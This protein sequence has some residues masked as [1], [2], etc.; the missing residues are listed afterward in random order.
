MFVFS[1]FPT[2]LSVSY[3]GMREASSLFVC[4]CMRLCVGPVGI[5]HQF[6]LDLMSRHVEISVRVHRSIMMSV[7]MYLYANFFQLNDLQHLEQLIFLSQVYDLPD[8]CH[9]CE[10]IF[11]LAP[12]SIQRIVEFARMHGLQ[13]LMTRCEMM[14][15]MSSMPSSTSSHS[16]Q[17]QEVY[18]RFVSRRRGFH[19]FFDKKKSIFFCLF[20]LMVCQSLKW[21]KKSKFPGSAMLVVVVL[22]RK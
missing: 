2:L 15:Q 17:M 5:D 21:M 3:V 7:L 14:R 11:P 16:L 6:S 10:E 22:K 19:P 12:N 9:Y 8:L 18:C 1:F 20:F 4:V 13:T